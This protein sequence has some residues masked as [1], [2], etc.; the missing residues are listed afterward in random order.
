MKDGC[1]ARRQHG[2]LLRLGRGSPGDHGAAING[3]GC[4]GAGGGHWLRGV[5]D[6]GR[7]RRGQREHAPGRCGSR[8]SHQLAMDGPDHGRLLWGIGSRDHGAAD[9]GIAGWGREP[10]RLAGGAGFDGR[11]K[12]DGCLREWRVGEGGT[13]TSGVSGIWSPCGALAPGGSLG[14]W[15]ATGVAISAGGV[16]APGGTAAIEGRLVCAA[17]IGGVCGPGPCGWTSRWM[18]DCANVSRPADGATTIGIA[19]APSDGAAAR[20]GA[21]SSPG[22]ICVRSA[23]ARWMRVAAA[24]GGCGSRWTMVASGLGGARRV[25]R[26]PRGIGL[27]VAS[28]AGGCEGWATRSMGNASVRG[29][30]KRSV[31]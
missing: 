1:G 3:G 18:G 13:A 29:P 10:G 16:W 22:W 8:R 27:T 15:V 12:V 5:D 14:G 20:D 7:E 17:W 23:G 24:T 9:V 31:W 4:R 30:V 19:G 28:G 11:R 25:R 21:G 6:R 26:G 2:L